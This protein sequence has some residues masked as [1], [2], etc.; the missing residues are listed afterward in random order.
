MTVPVLRGVK[1][2]TTC[3]VHH[4]REKVPLNDHH[5]WPLGHDGPDLAWNRVTLCMNGHGSVHA[6]LD[7]LLDHD[8]KLPW[9][10][11]REYGRHVRALA[12]KGYD[13]ILSKQAGR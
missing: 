12:Q 5:I 4:H 9:K 1:M 6:Y 8:G 7:L 11:R 13:A 3:A 2:G 10:V